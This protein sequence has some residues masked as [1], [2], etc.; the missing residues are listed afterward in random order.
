MSFHGAFLLRYSN[1]RLVNELE[2]YD[3]ASVRRVKRKNN[4]MLIPTPALFITF[5]RLVLPTSVKL[6]WLNLYVKPFVPNPTRCFLCQVYGQISQTSRRL[7]SRHFKKM[8]ALWY[9]YPR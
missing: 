7:S 1:V 2:N 9:E 6:A 3:V 5:N 8:C 4:G